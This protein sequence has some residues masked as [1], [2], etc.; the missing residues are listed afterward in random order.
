MYKEYLCMQVQEYNVLIITKTIQTSG[1]NRIKKK[2]S[3][4]SQGY[5][6]EEGS[7]CTRRKYSKNQCRIY[8]TN[9]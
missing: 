5:N 2:G 8:W 7:Q 3:Y 4:K 6:E 1:E 9:Q